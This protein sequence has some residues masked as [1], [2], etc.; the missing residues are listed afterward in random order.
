[1]TDHVVAALVPPRVGAGVRRSS[2]APGRL[3]MVAL[4]SLQRA[5][6]L[7]YAMARVD[8]ALVG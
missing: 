4:M 5:G 6:V 3:P 8:A 2:S 7:R 1:M